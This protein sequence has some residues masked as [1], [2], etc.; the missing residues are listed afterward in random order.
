MPTEGAPDDSLPGLRSIR[1]RNVGKVLHTYALDMS[2]S[3][4]DVARNLDTLADW[5]EDR[6]AATLGAG[7]PAP[8]N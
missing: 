1:V 8:T 2:G 7:G 4:E 3:T 6:A 5:L